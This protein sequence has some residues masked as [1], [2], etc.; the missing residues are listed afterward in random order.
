MDRFAQPA[1]YKR[2]LSVR[3]FD[4]AGRHRIGRPA[5]RFQLRH[6]ENLH[7]AVGPVLLDEALAVVRGFFDDFGAVETIDRRSVE[8]ADPMG[9]TA[10]ATV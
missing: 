1:Q 10:P 8:F 9:F 4:V 7:D 3:D 2:R 5:T 6:G